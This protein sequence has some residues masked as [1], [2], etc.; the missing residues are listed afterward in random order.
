MKTHGQ[1]EPN[2]N[3]DVSM[4]AGQS[5]KSVDPGSIDTWTFISRAQIMGIWSHCLAC[6]LGR[7]K[8]KCLIPNDVKL[9]VSK[10]IR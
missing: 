7:S 1:V 3:C 5:L 6:I 9:V 8:E 4:C 10:A 2:E